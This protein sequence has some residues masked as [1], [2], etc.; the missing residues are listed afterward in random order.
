MLKKNKNIRHSFLEL[1]IVA[2]SSSF[3]GLGERA[4]KLQA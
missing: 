1:N 3:F 2:L 4:A